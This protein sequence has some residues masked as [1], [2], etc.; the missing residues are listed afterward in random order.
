[1]AGDTI[2]YCLE[3]LTDY[4][5]FERLCQDLMALEG[6]PNI[7]PLGG[8]KD[9]GRDAVHVDR[10]TGQNTIFCYSVRED[11]RAKLE[12]DAAKIRGHK[13]PCDRLVYLSTS[14]YSPGERDSAIA[15]IRDT[16]HWE[17]ESFGLERLR[18]LLAGTRR[19]LIARHPQIFTPAFFLDPPRGPTDSVACDS[20]FVSY[21]PEDVALA[22]WLSRRLIAE[23]YRVWCESLEILGGSP[24]QETIERR[25]QT[26]SFRLLALYSL[27]SLDK[28]DVALQRNL[29]HT[30]ATQRGGEF[31]IPLGVEPIPDEKLDWKTRQLAFI[32][33]DRSWADGL[34]QLLQRLIAIDCP[35]PVD[36]GRGVVA[37]SLLRKAVVS[38]A[39]EPIIS[40]CLPVD[41]IPDAV[42]RFHSDREIGLDEQKQLLSR[43]AFHAVSPAHFLSFQKPPSADRAAFGL[44]PKGGMDI[45]YH[46]AIDGCLTANLI[47]ELVRKSLVVKCHQRGMRACPAKG[48]L[49]FPPDMAD[50]GRLKY[51]CLDGSK[52]W[53]GAVGRRKYWRPDK[54][55]DYC[56][57]LSPTFAVPQARDGPL[58]VLVRMRVY[59]TDTQGVPLGRRKLVSRRKHLCRG[60]WNQ[61]WLAR[62]LALCHFLADGGT[63]ITVGA[64]DDEQVV[65]CAS[66]RRWDAPVS[67]DEKA[68]DR[69]SLEQDESIRDDDSDE[70]GDDDGDEKGDAA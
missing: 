30:I 38:A 58:V 6:Y 62:I 15:F 27:V 14:D 4:A 29:A 52:S 22:T 16:Y 36:G 41:R 13:H 35:R 54:S 46:A 48:Y 8:F 67:I 31:L 33:F 60:W 32:P 24:K 70:E 23:G 12:E 50:G 43:W 40:N 28:P 2:I 7:E 57:S 19:H 65:V 3:K 51:V 66:P 53:V 55:E 20:L 64:V 18:V 21:A 9:K 56:Y 61:E 47:P 39:P 37:S 59:L 63:S 42:L 10:A 34:R 5:Q 49:F 1:M 26:R 68:L 69:E 45:Q 25:I 44:T 11:W 17:L